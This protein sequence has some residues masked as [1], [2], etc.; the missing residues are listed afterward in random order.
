MN[1]KP[2]TP[3]YFT[4]VAADKKWVTTPCVWVNGNE[5]TIVEIFKSSLLSQDQQTT[6]TH[7]RHN[8]KCAQPPHHRIADKVDLAMVFHPEILENVM[9]WSRDTRRIH[10]LLTIPLLNLGQASGLESNRCLSVNPALV[11]HITCCNSRNL[12]KNP[13]RR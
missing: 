12:A 9:S 5:R 4:T 6:N 2:Q 3:S 11:V 8:S 1:R 13:G 7:I 10:N